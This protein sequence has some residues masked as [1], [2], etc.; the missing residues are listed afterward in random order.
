MASADSS[1]T[2]LTLFHP[3]YLS[4]GL[5]LYVLWVSIYRLYFSPLAKFPGPKIAGM[6]HLLIKSKKIMVSHASYG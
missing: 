6:L 4:A 2:L 5:I 1:V 3:L